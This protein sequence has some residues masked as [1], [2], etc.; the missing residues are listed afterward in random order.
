MTTRR[1]VLALAAAALLSPM[2]SAQALRRPIKLA[3]FSAGTLA[4]HKGYLDAFR[5]G[6]KEQGYVEGRDF[7]IEYFWR[8]ETI[9]PFGWIARD[10][11]NAR[12]DM[13]MSTCEVTASAA[14]KATQSIPIILTASTDPVA[15]GIVP[16]LARPGGN[17]TGVSSSL[18]EVNVKR[19]ELMKELIPAASRVTL[20]KWKY[21]LVGAAEMGAIERAARSAGIALVSAEAED[22]SDFERVFADARR[23]RMSG[24]LDMAGLAWSFPFQDLLPELEVRHKMPVVHFTRELVE[25][26]G[27]VSYGPSLANGF[28]RSAKYVDRVAKGARPGDLPIEQPDQF[29]L[30]VNLRTARA[31]GIAVPSSVL[32]RA[33]RVIE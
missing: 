12:P 2:A 10:I 15:N 6:M 27:L 21:E 11:V 23:A 7:T 16:S 30:C 19:V 20:L 32:V 13:I 33:D 24:I 8:G 17:V 3:W 9:K 5:E 1:D 31:I 26:G 29:E 25:H 18:V 4:D 28:R 14:K 22:G